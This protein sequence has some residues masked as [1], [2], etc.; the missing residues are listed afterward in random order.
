MLGRHLPF[1]L[2]W[3]CLLVRVGGSFA[4]WLGADTASVRG[5]QDN[6][7]VW[8]ASS[9]WLGLTRRAA[10]TGVALCVCCAQSATMANADRV[11]LTYIWSMKAKMTE[12]SDSTISQNALQFDNAIGFA[13]QGNAVA[14][15]D[16]LARLPEAVNDASIS[17][18]RDS[19]N[20]RFGP[21]SRPTTDVNIAD[22]WIQALVNGYITYWHSV[23]THQQPQ[24]VAEDS[25]RK[26]IAKLLE[27]STATSAGDDDADAAV[28]EEARKRGYYVL[29]GR[30]FPLLELMLWQEQRVEDVAVD[31][32]EGQQFVSVNYL[33]K[34]V[35][36][37]WGHYATCGQRS[38]G[39][40]AT[41]DGLF[42]VV[43]AYDRIDDETFT[44]R[45]L[46]H[47]AQHTHDLRTFGDLQG[48]G[49][50]Y[51]AKLA[52]LALAST[53]QRE[54]LQLI[55]ENRN[56]DIEAP[57]SY[58]NFVVIKDLEE[59]LN[60]DTTSVNLCTDAI[61]DEEALRQAAKKLLLADSCSRKLHVE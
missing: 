45:F 4:T 60:T 29:L 31:L 21:K 1:S 37:G 27:G 5:K 44:V 42:A 56:N 26:A 55:C 12:S 28:Q 7:W 19:M 8:G 36:R 48:W 18:F 58:A 15:L 10:Q 13:L 16:A 23:L 34:F 40:W 2:A 11:T 50:E 41:T 53:T 39:G 3:A 49:L 51:R 25:L 6:R 33:D 43:P 38:A 24:D 57:H 22:E 17:E 9:A 32:P 54:T 59:A 35:M 47:E 14:A 30:T 52:E 20:Q 46:G 61:Q